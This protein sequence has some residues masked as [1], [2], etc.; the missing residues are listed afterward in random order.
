MWAILNSENPEKRTRKRL[1]P[2]VKAQHEVK[3][4]F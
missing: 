4:I 3:L 1:F 2:R